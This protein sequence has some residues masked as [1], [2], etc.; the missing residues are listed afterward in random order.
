MVL[1]LAKADRA[2][3]RHSLLAHSADVGAMVEA[4]LRTGTIGRRLAALAGV[5]ALTPVDIGRLSLLAALHD[6]GKA[7]RGFLARIDDLCW[8]DRAGH[9][10]PVVDLLADGYAGHPHRLPPVYGNLVAASGL[11]AVFRWFGGRRKAM[12]LVDAVLMHHGRLPVSGNPETKLWRS[13]DGYDPMSALEPIG[14]VLPSWF[15]AA[16]EAGAAGHLLE[17]RFLH[18][19]A[20]LVMLADWI[21]SSDLVC[22]FVTD[23]GAERIDV[24]RRLAAAA[25]ERLRLDP[26]WAAGALPETGAAILSAVL[27][28]GRAPR[29]TQVAMVSAVV[30][31]GSLVVI[32]AETGSGK[33][34]AAI[35]HFANLMR[36]GLVDGL[37]FA[38]PTRAAAVQIHRRVVEALDRVMGAAAPPA[39]L[40]LP[41]YLRA[42]EMEGMALPDFAVLWPDDSG[43]GR[44]DAAW[45]AEHPKRFMAAAVAVGSIDQVMLGGLSVRHAELRSS[46]LLRQL[47]VIDEV[48][49]SDNY[50]TAIVANL[51]AQHR[52]AGGHALLMS[53]TLGTAA[54]LRLMGASQ[55]E[56]D[57]LP[58]ADD[59]ARQ[60]YPAIHGRNARIPAPAAMSGGGKSVA[61]DCVADLDH[62]AIA[63]LAFEA[64]V[65]GAR[66]LVIRN[67]VDDACDT[68]RALAA[69]AERA[70]RPELVFRCNGVATVHHGRFAPADRVLLDPAL[71]AALG[72]DSTA[73]IVCVTTQT[74]EQSLDIDADYLITDLCPADVLL[75]RIGRL[76][77]HL[78]PARPE[79]FRMPRLSVHA[80]GEARLAALI[81]GRGAIAK[82]LLGLG[83]VYPNLLGIVATRRALIDL[84]VI[85]IPDHNRLLVERATH[86]PALRALAE[87][88]GPAWSA[89]LNTVE[90]VTLAQ[91]QVARFNMLDFTE[92][93]MPLPDAEGVVLTRLGA[94]ARI[95]RVAPAFESVLGARIEQLSIPGWML[96]VE[97][98]ETALEKVEIGED[99][100]LSV[101]GSAFSYTAYGLGKA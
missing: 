30:E 54:R 37:Y 53:A 14:R 67:R 69:L 65:Q 101:G 13:G 100:A 47:L 98:D 2:G 95:V 73:P 3:R 84:G 92:R 71:E 44:R 45:A 46:P 72:P 41:G 63:G 68:A 42:G 33:T 9:I 17:G 83:R 89:H 22:D 74:A 24:S 82:G 5:E 21:A 18:G 91:G 48:H 55:G 25:V 32:E 88:L 86:P 97:R 59:L 85:R 57:A 96:G 58:A 11:D 70:G 60:P 27:G 49:A 90:G 7:N 80:P 29:P 66:V 43:D 77:R 16:F 6:L 51:I 19:F 75:Q 4:L 78:R 64:A 40:A 61:V 23:A 52:A 12:P 99:G 87:D 94:D 8:P 93:P 62:A 10:K 79:G 50:M 31:P 15:G 34:E 28:G 26:A 81:D 36:L 1:A 20:G 56:I 76:H 39:V 38:L 35:A